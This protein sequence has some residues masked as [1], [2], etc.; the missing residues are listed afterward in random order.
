[1]VALCGYPWQKEAS[2]KAKGSGLSD[3]SY[4][5][6]PTSRVGSRHSRQPQSCGFHC[7]FHT[8]HWGWAGGPWTGIPRLFRNLSKMDQRLSLPMY[9]TDIVGWNH[10]I[11]SQKA[12]LQ[13]GWL[14]GDYSAGTGEDKEDIIHV[15]SAAA[16]NSELSP[17]ARLPYAC[18]TGYA[19]TPPF[20]Q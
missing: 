8:R 14:S 7:Q 5:P 18:I 4:F 12:P 10:Q 15:T 13:A 11:F 16:P 20:T 2:D 1:M 3:E 9:A 17:K 19:T 6:N